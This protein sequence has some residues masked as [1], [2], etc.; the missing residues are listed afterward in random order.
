MT[1][2]FVGAAELMSSVLGASGYPF[3]TIEH[4]VSSASQE[5]LDRRAREIA[6][7]VVRHLTRSDRGA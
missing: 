1:E 3:V 5:A 7:E 6:P 2:Q 4:P